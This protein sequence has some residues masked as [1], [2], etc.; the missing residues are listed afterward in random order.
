VTT[1][2]TRRTSLTPANDLAATWFLS[3]DERGNAHSRVDDHADP[4]TAWST[5]NLVRPLIHG[6]AYFAELL[7][8]VRRLERGDLLLFTDW[9]GDADERLDGADTEVG[10]VFSEAARRGVIVRCLMW[11]SHSTLLQFSEPQN[12]EFAEVLTEAGAEVLLDTRVRAGGCHHQKLVVLRHRGRPALDVAYVGGIDVCH[13]RNDDARHEGDPQAVPMAPQYGPRPP[14]H[15]VQVAI[16]GPAVGMVE[17]SFRERWEDPAPVTTNPVRVARDV[18]DDLPLDGDALPPQP[19]DPEPVGGH[20]VQLLRTYPYKKPGFPFAPDGERSVARGYAKAVARARRL[21]YLEDQYLWSPEV[22]KVFADALRANPDLRVVAVVPRHPD[23][24]S[25]MTRIPQLLGRSRALATMR[26]ADPDRVAVYSPE[27]AD[28]TPVYVHAKVCVIDDTWATVGSDNLN[29]RSWTYDSE[30]SC[31]VLDD[32]GSYGRGL[33][34]ALI[35]EHLGREVE[36]DDVFDAFA[37]SASTLDRWYA[38]GR[39]GPRPPGMVRRYGPP[40]LHWATRLWATPLYRFIC[41]PDGRP[42]RLR[43]RGEF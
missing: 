1:A 39:A 32:S 8:R 11:R 28:G 29:M 37:A 19:A 40:R 22:A 38:D 30:L 18:S 42:R 7:A 33:R 23:Q 31:A 20:T 24:A 21:I 14:W 4:G 41:D 12:R 13:G 43:L 5:G 26:A 34:Q 9:R 10:R 15:D 35:R 2:A 6:H 36:L 3:R 27:N 17:A 16:E 25:A